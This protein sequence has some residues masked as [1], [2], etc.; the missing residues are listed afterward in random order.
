VAGVTIVDVSYDRQTAVVT[1]DDARTDLSALTEATAEV[2][3][4][5]VL[6]E[7]NADTN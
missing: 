2:G 7:T 5:A 4:P 6:A 1:Y 3:F